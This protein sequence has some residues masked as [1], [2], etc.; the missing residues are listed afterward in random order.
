MKSILW[1]IC[2]LIRCSLIFRNLGIFQLSFVIDSMFNSTVVWEKTLYDFYLF[3]FATYI[4]WTKMC[5]ILVI[6]LYELEKNEHFA[7]A[8]WSCLEMS[9][10][11]RWWVLLLSSTMSLLIFCLLDTSIY[12]GGKLKSPTLIVD[13]STFLYLF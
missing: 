1:P 10:I 2:Y 13:S 4:L 9:I 5:S 12:D 7:A 8:G 11:S 3:G 6:V